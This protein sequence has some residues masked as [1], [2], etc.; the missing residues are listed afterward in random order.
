MKDWLLVFLPVVPELRASEVALTVSLCFVVL[1]LL[2]V[3]LDLVQLFFV[4]SLDG[5][6]VVVLDLE[7][8][9]LMLMVVLVFV[10]PLFLPVLMFAALVLPEMAVSSNLLS[11]LLPPSERKVLQILVVS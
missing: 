10:C 4:L 9:L 8:V 11:S 7:S 2:E 5:L 1:I 3:A 6:P